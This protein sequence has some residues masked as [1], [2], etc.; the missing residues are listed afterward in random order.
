MDRIVA[1]TGFE[2]VVSA[3]RGRR[4]K[5]LDERACILLNKIPLKIYQQSQNSKLNHD[6]VAQLS[7]FKL[8]STTILALI[9]LQK[10]RNQV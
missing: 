5:P 8:P 2:P 3:L 10:V 9:K 4:P 1:R 6:N 7:L